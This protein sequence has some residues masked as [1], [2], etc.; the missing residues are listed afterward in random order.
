MR[1]ILVVEDERI[2]QKVAML[3]LKPLNFDVDVVDT[4]E[5][6]LTA[7]NQKQYDLILMDF[8]LPDGVKGYDVAQRIKQHEPYA[9]TPIVGLTAHL[10]PDELQK[11]LKMG[12]VEC[13]AKPLTMEAVQHLCGTYFSG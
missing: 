3:L 10:K 7:I 8:G 6:A 11:A 4:G 13:L 1:K 9:K 2:A 12:M 5:K